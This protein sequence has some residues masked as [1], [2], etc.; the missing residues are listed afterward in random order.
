MP[1]TLLQNKAEE[2]RMRAT[3]ISQAMQM[4][5]NSELDLAPEVNRVALWD[6]YLPGFKEGTFSGQAEFREDGQ[7]L[8]VG[9][10]HDKRD[11]V[12]LMIRREGSSTR[13]TE[14]RHFDGV[15]ATLTVT[16]VFSLA[17]KLLAYEEIF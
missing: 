9:V 16:A 8:M 15:S 1:N 5:D 17:G 4:I 10:R 11:S 3:S 6:A 2:L 7:I 14:R 12:D 13:V